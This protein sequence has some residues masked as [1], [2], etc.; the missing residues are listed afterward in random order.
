MFGLNNFAVVDDVDGGKTAGWAAA[1]FDVGVVAG[2]FSQVV[3][4]K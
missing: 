1:K 2:W 4:I 3:A